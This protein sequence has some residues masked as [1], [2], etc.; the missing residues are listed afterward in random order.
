MTRLTTLVQKSRLKHD[1][2]HKQERSR[3][4]LHSPERNISGY[5]V[6]SWV[7]AKFIEHKSNHGQSRSGTAFRTS[8][9]T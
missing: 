6:F 1:W 9:N 8:N 3:W 7:N 4:R 2:G 5:A